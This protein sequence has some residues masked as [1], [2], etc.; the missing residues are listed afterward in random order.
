[1]SWISTELHFSRVAGGTI[2]RQSNAEVIAAK[3]S[4]KLHQN[5]G[6]DSEAAKTSTELHQQQVRSVRRHEDAAISS[7]E[8]HRRV[9]DGHP[10][11]FSLSSMAS[12]IQTF[13]DI[14]SGRLLIAASIR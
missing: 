8:L 6:R 7:T 4:T 12:L 9:S 2:G 3:T 1:M 14:L 10:S 5:A 11:I 13:I